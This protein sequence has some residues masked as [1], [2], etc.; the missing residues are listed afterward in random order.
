MK[1]FIENLDSLPI[2]SRELID[3]KKYSAHLKTQN[4]P[5]TTIMTSRGCPFQCIY[6]SK[7]ITGSKLRSVSPENVIK[8]IEHLINNYGI[9]EIIFYDDSFTLDRERAIKICDLIIQKNIRIKWQCETRVNLVDEGLLKKMK[10][11][12][13][14]TIAYGI[15]SGSN[16]VLNILKKGITTEQIK[17]AVGMTKKAGIQTI[18]YFMLGIPGETEKEITQTINFAKSLSLD[19]AQF[20]IATAYPGTELYQMAKEQNKLTNDWSK[21]IYAL[22]G[23]PTVSLSEIDIDKLYKYAKKAYHEFYFR[24]KYILNRIKKIK[25]PKNLIYNLRGLKTLIKI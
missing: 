23:K 15:E 10:Q 18:G 8:E 19:F 9:K 21:S 11:A 25:S 12:G 13:C 16:R 4:T 14:A 22:G 7:P 2:P 5:A 1:N 17:T 6:C 20:A 3:M 24:P